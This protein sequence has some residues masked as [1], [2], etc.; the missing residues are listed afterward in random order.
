VLSL[1]GAEHHREL[2]DLRREGLDVPN[3][4]CPRATA[5][6]GEFSTAYCH[7]VAANRKILREGRARELKPA[8]DAHADR[9]DTAAKSLESPTMAKCFSD[10]AFE[11][12]FEDLVDAP[13]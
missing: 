7:V 4:D 1:L 11:Q 9:F 2:V 10:P 12:A 8:L 5:R 6:L 3:K 13:P